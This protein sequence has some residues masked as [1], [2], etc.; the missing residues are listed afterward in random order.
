MKVILAIFAK[1]DNFFSVLGHCFVSKTQSTF[2][3][4]KGW[5]LKMTILHVFD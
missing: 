3:S 4:G 5:E 1:R 2:L